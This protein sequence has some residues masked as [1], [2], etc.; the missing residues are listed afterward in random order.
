MSFFAFFPIYTHSAV[1]QMSAMVS[2]LIK[3]THFFKR[4]AQVL[5]KAYTQLMFY[6]QHMNLLPS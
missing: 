4:A 3:G 5:L 1:L 6:A 2:G